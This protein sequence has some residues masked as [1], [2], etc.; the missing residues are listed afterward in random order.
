MPVMFQADFEVTTPNDFKILR[1]D[2]SIDEGTILLWDPSRSGLASYVN[3]SIFPD[4]ASEVS[5]ATIGV[6]ASSLGATLAI[7]AIPSEFIVEKT[8]KG[9]LHIMAT[10]NVLGGTA[11]RT[12]LPL[13]NALKS[14]IDARPNNDYTVRFIGVFTR[15]PTLEKPFFFFSR[16]SY[17][18]NNYFYMRRNGNTTAGSGGGPSAN[19]IYTPSNLP[20]VGVPFMWTTTFNSKSGTWDV[21]TD[22]GAILSGLMVGDFGSPATGGHASLIMYQAEINNRTVSGKSAAQKQAEDLAYFNSLFATDGRLA[23]DTWTT[24]AI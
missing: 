13:S 11:R 9:G 8:L 5:A 6:S 17:T 4:I 2:D 1:A 14:Y 22:P 20:A 23:N 12:S 24:P 7:P 18:S 15:L 16:T 10:Q 3:G 21:L 19:A